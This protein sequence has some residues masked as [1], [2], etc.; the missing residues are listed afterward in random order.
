MSKDTTIIS[1]TRYNRAKFTTSAKLALTAF[2]VMGFIGGW[3]MIGRVEKQLNRN[4]KPAPAPS[5]SLWPTPTSITVSP[6][7]W[8]TIQP[9][10]ELP[11]IPTLVPTFTT[12]G[13]PAQSGT[14]LDTAPSTSVQFVPI[15]TLAPLPALE[16]PTIPPP[17]PP[18]L[19]PPIPAGG[20]NSSG[21]S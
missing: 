4:D 19:P 11:P 21:G 2:S 16:L 12:V 5:P 3:N 18:P 7:P 10:T 9:L 1:S 6:T 14:Q 13:H 17:P 20:G 8:P 15:P